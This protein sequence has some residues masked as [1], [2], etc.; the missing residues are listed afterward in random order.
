MVGRG[1]VGFL[2]V[3]ALLVLSGCQGAHKTAARPVAPPS[4]PTPV[5]TNPARVGSDR[6]AA[7]LGLRE[8]WVTP[9]SDF[10]LEGAS[11]S[12]QF[13]VGRRE[14]LLNGWKVFLGDPPRI[15]QGQVWFS[16]SDVDS[17]LRPILLGDGLQG[18]TGVRTVAIDAGHGGHESG[19]RNQGLGLAE[20]DLTLD[21]ARRLA[22]LLTGRGYAVI[23]TRVDDTHVPLDERPKLARGADLFISIHFNATGNTAVTGTETYVLSKAGQASTG[24]SLPYDGDTSMLPGNQFDAPSAVFGF[25]VQRGLVDAFGTIDRGLKYARFAVLKGL[26]CPGILVESAFLSNRAEASRVADPAF[27]QRLAETLVRG[28]EAYGSR[29]AGNDR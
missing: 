22:T 4:D 12:L 28:I 3:S 11:G 18:V 27:R 16:G 1:L 23:L 6:V 25:E 17:L 20:K 19:T 5:A 21:V 10:V 13:S 9:G 26:P 29:I 8:R 2:F 24:A 7:Q 15:D 14:T